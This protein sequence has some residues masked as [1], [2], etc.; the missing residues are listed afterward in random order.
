MIHLLLIAIYVITGKLAL[1]LA[2]P[3]GYAYPIFPAAG[4]AI[5]AAFIAGRKVLPAIFIA[6]LLLN[7][8]TSYS[9]HSHLDV[10]SFE[11]ALMIA[12]AS[13][14]QAAIAG[15]VLRHVIGYP[16]FLSQ[17][18]D[19]FKFLLLS[20]ILCLTSATLSV[21]AL[22]ALG[23][24]GDDGVLEMFASWWVGDALGLVIAFP[25]V[26]VFAGEPRR[27][28]R[29]RVSTV[30]VPMLVVL[31]LFV[32]IYFKANQ[33][34]QAD[35][36]VQFRQHSS[37]LAD[38]IR[39]S[40][41]GQEA[42]VEQVASLFLLDQR[43][44]VTRQ[45]FRL[46]VE[47]SLQRFTMIQAISWE[48]RVDESHREGFEAS[49]R[50]DVAG[51]EI[52]QRNSGGQLQRAEKRTLYYPVTYIE[53]IA[54]NQ[55]AIGFDLMSNALR[56]EALNRSIQ[57]GLA[58]TSAPLHLVQ[59]QQQQEGVLLLMAVAKDKPVGAVSSVL[60]M[61]DFMDALLPQSQPM[62]FAR[63][64]DLDAQKVVYDRFSSAQ[65]QPLF[66]ERFEFGSR[67]YQLETV[68]T[69]L[70]LQQHRGWQ[71]WGILGA[72]ALAVGLMGALLLLATG[73]TSRMQEEVTKRTNQLRE[74]E[75][76]LRTIVE[77]EPECIAVIDAAG[78]LLQV[79][80]AGLHYL[81]ADALEQVQGQSVLPFLVPEFR[82]PFQQLHARVLAGESMQMICELVGLR[83]R[84]LWMEA[85]AV[86]IQRQGEVV[87]LTVM[88]DI[89]LRKQLEEA[90][91]ESF[92]QLQKVASSVPGMVYQFRLRPDGSTSFPF[93]SEAIRDIFRLTPEA[94]RMDATAVFA[95]FHPD[96]YDAAM[97][98]IHQSAAT[99]LPW[100]HE[101]RIR[102]P[103]GT[104]NWL[105]GN[106]IPEKEPDGSVLWYGFISN[107]N[108]R[109]QAEQAIR[110]SEATFR[111]MVETL[112]LAIYVS[113]GL[114]QRCE[115]INHTCIEWFGYSMAGCPNRCRV[116][117][118][119]LSGSFL[120][121]AA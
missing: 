29:S 119:S 8:W 36:L 64:I 3:P 55:A 49:Q 25:L 120:S 112:P 117:A 79:N 110:D 18:S 87:H 74:R 26:M 41:H 107:I 53:P 16:T 85:H 81:Q 91:E 39:S 63:L 72:G 104:V 1:L 19:I 9:T 56:A 24:V 73:Y 70:Y 113:T 23:V 88:R 54:G 21:S 2:L 94:V 65:L 66:V 14:L 97:A 51:F 48:Y 28:W 46:F 31:V 59:E 95:T 111:A 27:L 89:T 22:R 7:V 37:Q 20:P 40:F 115:Y 75:V 71:S 47:K 106:A 4:I 102:L 38:Q 90:R 93:A 15:R 121:P 83:G 12:L 10:L 34:E 33:W 101:W 96:D 42:L 105:Y 98:S 35:S 109:K 118:Q 86:P 62:L 82:Q 6:S 50:T 84:H 92:S 100:Y 76:Y 11:I 67:H 77:N 45:Q 103:D 116:V 5:A 114:E 108:A 32:A 78:S 43:E 30:A 17:G 69:P 99:L 13:M 44:P 52:R 60:R 58:I 68:P 61:G 80:P 57:S